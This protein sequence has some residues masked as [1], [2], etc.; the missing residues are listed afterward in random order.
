MLR[1]IL[2]GVAVVLLL[3]IVT[4][5]LVLRQMV[6]GGTPSIHHTIMPGVAATPCAS[7]LLPAGSRAFRIN[8]QMSTAS[9]E[10]H[11]QVAGQ[12]VPG[13]VTGVTGDV[14]GEFLLGSDSE[15]TMLAMKIEVDLRSL[16]SGAPQRDAH[17]RNDTL[18]TDKYPFVTFN[19]SNAHMLPQSYTEGQTVNFK[20][21]GELTL[22]GVT[23]TVTFEMQGKLLGDTATG[24]G[25]TLIHLQDF[26]MRTPETTAVVTVTVSKDVMLLIHFTAQ[27]ER[28]VHSM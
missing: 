6:F 10:A 17:V 2:I 8:S 28:C 18:E 9:Y 4:T 14:S 22:H 11:F 21:V 5:V 25:S 15:P 19:V 1:R 26:H 27:Q 7:T 12:N 23:R 13:T 3:G 20:L 16:D 24:S